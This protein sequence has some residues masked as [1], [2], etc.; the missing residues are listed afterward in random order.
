MLSTV[1]IGCAVVAVQA[2]L[3]SPPARA[4]TRA[5][6]SSACSPPASGATSV[7]RAGG[8]RET[9][10]AQSRAADVSEV[11]LDELR[12][13]VKG[14][15]IVDP[16][17]PDPHASDATLR[18]FLRAV[19][20]EDVKHAAQ[21]LVS[22]AR[23]RFENKPFLW[24]CEWCERRPG[25]HTWRQVG[26]DKL[27]RP[28]IYSCLAQAATHRYT[29]TCAVRHM[30]YA[31]E[32]AV[33]TMPDGEDGWLWICDFSGF[34]LRAC[35]L[36]VASGVIHIVAA[37]YPERL[38][39]FAC[40]NAPR[41]FMPAWRAICKL[42]DPRTTRKTRFVASRDEARALL[43]DI[44]PAEDADWTMDELTANLVRPMAVC[45]SCDGFWRPP[46]AGA[47]HDPRGT[48]TY[49]QRYLGADRARAGDCLRRHRPHPNI[50]LSLAGDDDAAKEAVPPVVLAPRA[51]CATAQAS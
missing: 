37:H 26:Q 50:A 31:I 13:L 6:A 40:V 14:Q 41:L 20:G 8:S 24:T 35:D 16:E 46:S 27:G 21:R 7:G 23:W 12:A 18:R 44:L 33:R 42:V 43:C 19:G 51:P 36:S 17:D 2:F 9:Q 32:Q 45:Q 28:V 49:V 22:T 15:I 5:A 11:R 30:V 4:S 47:T 1:L 25:H 10:P 29:A 38:A 39:L 3:A 48:P 34:T